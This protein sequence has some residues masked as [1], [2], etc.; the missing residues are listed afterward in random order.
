M[1]S[2]SG[3]VASDRREP[4]TISPDVAARWREAI[5]VDTFSNYHL[6]MGEAMRAEDGAAAAAA[7]ERAIAIKPDLWL[8]HWRLRQILEEMGDAKAAAA[9]HQR[10]LAGNPDYEARA[11]WA[12]ALNDIDANC[13]DDGAEALRAA[14]ERRPAWAEES[15]DGMECLARYHESKGS[16][17]K[18]GEWLERCIAARPADAGLRGRLARAWIAQGR[19]VDA[20]A[21][22]REAARLDPANSDSWH[23]LCSLCLSLARASLAAQ[24]EKHALALCPGQEFS[25]Y[26][27]LTH[28]LICLGRHA[29]AV[30][31]AGFGARVAPRKPLALGGVGLALLAADRIDEAAAAFRRG[32]SL[33]SGSPDAWTLS[34]LGLALIRQGAMEEGQ[35]CLERAVALRQ[36]VNWARSGLGWALAVQGRRGAALELLRAGAAEEAHMVG[37]ELW[38]RPWLAQDLSPLYAELGIAVE[39]PV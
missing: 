26:W 23:I 32:V 13:F 5:R 37:F 27:H 31:Q 39:P 17:A 10:A 30:K 24:A 21:Q 7:F 16:Y 36:N 38:S 20:E 12:A 15:L 19:Q 11:H 8:A 2:T 29:E 3:P 14:L 33:A 6:H 9:A 28:A 4:A 34:G 25:F 35:A 22:L 1:L 18:A